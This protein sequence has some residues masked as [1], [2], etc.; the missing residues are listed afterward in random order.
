MSRPGAHPAAASLPGE[1]GPV[2]TRPSVDK[3][4]LPLCAAPESR[5]GHAGRLGLVAW[6]LAAQVHAGVPAGLETMPTAQDVMG[7]LMAAAAHHAVDPALLH[8]MAVVES[9]L[10]PRATN[11]S[12]KNG[13]RDIGLMQIN[14][15]WLPTL[16]RWGI[17]EERLYEPC[18]SAYVGAWILAGNI[19]RHGRTW[20][21]VGAYNAVTPSRQ[22]AYVRRV[23]KQLSKSGRR[24]TPSRASGTPRQAPPAHRQDGGAPSAV[25]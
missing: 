7:C 6:L 16:G 22:L 23:Q 20:R 5:A 2:A 10:D 18:I 1:P 24:Q 21:A 3:Q 13:S 19:A 15:A 4:P 14:S 17:T 12:N 9:G 25:R 8:A 11:R